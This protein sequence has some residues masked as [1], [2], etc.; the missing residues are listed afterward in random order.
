MNNWYER[1]MDRLPDQGWLK[2]PVLGLAVYLLLAVLV[3]MY[4]SVTPAA[5][6]VRERAA[7]YAAAEGGTVVTGSVTT[8]ALIGV[9]DTLLD[10]P[11]GYLHND[12]FPPGL[13]LDN[14]P[15]WEYGALIQVRDLS[16]ALRE[17]HSRSQSQ[18]TEDPDL[19]IAE[20]RYNFNASSWIL[21]STESQYR[22]GLEYTRNYFR[23]LSDESQPDAQFYARADNLRYWLSTVNTRLGSAVAAP[24][25]QRRPASHQH[26]P[27]K[28][29]DGRKS[30][31]RMRLRRGDCEDPVAG[32]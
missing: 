30:V 25:C 26:G 27:G 3:G 6:E 21:P 11:G 9:M 17:V 32:D 10:K 31:H 20:P 22:E 14:M 8:G 28:G 18:S 13:W 15:W 24:Q 2:W 4:W 19:A 1:L 29:D 23:R 7:E 16:R 12:R 5:F